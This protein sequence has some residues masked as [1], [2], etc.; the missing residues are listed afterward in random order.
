MREPMRHQHL[1]SNN[2]LRYT[3]E[4][5]AREQWGP[6]VARAN[7]ECKQYRTDME[8]M[9]KKMNEMSLD[10]EAGRSFKKMVKAINDNP[11]AK[12]YWDK[13]LAMMRLTE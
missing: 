4:E 3:C 12:S 7:E 5:Y 1:D 13:M 11:A 9:Q 6:I 2:S 10:A 8:R